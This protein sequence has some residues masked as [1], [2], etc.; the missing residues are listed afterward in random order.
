MVIFYLGS[1]MSSI[2]NQFSY[3]RRLGNAYVR[4]QQQQHQA[5]PEV[6]T[7]ANAEYDPASG[8]YMIKE[9][10]RPSA[11]KSVQWILDFSTQW[12]GHCKKLVPEWIKLAQK[13]QGTK[14]MPGYVDCG[15]LRQFCEKYKIEGYPTIKLFSKGKIRTYQG[16]RTAGAIYRWLRKKA[17]EFMATNKRGLAALWEWLIN[18]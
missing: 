4:T 6:R 10:F 8:V 12:C 11:D 16:A 13:L 17:P 9:G 5:M 7:F 2:E 14:T 15:E 3:Q 1:A 18:L